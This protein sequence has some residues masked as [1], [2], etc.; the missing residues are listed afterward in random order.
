MSLTSIHEDADSILGLAQW[1]KDPALPWAVVYVGPRCGLDLVLLWLWYRPTSI[2][3][4][5]PL[6][7]ELPYATSVALKKKKKKKKRLE[8][9][10]RQRKDRERRWAICWPH[11]KDSKKST[12]PTLWY[13]TASL[14]DDRSGNQ[15]LV[16]KPPPYGACLSKV[17]RWPWESNNT[18]EVCIQ[19]LK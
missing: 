6:A 16:L 11:G 12:L 15:F 9:M 14:Q 4:I 10:L 18:R 5:Q 3:L 8:H 1:V 13:Q 17:K 19:K 7:W 2:A